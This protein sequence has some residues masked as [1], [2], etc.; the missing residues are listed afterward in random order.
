MMSC[1]LLFIF[2]VIF[3]IF[4]GVIITNILAIKAI[5]NNNYYDPVNVTIINIKNSSFDIPNEIYFM[6]NFYFYYNN[7]IKN[8]PVI[9]K[10]KDCV[11]NYGKYKINDNIIVYLYGNEFKFIP[12]P[13]IFGVFYTF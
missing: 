4:I 13:E 8:T 9:C 6:Y 3:C 7:T 2:F 10:N 1:F 11:V 5:I 12:F